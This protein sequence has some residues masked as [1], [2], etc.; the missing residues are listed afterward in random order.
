M[1]YNVNGIRCWV[2]TH[3]ALYIAVYQLE[4]FKGSILYDEWGSLFVVCLVPLIPLIPLTRLAL[5]PR[6]DPLLC[7]VACVCSWRVC[8]VSF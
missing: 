8:T 7:S 6:S 3:I 1:Q 4:L 2:L 5:E